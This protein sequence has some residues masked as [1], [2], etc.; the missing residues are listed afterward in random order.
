MEEHGFPIAPAI[1]GLVLGE[2]LEQSFMT[3]MIKADGNFI[4]FFERPIAAV[5]GVMTIL[6]WATMIWRG[7]RGQKA[8]IAPSE[9]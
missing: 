4:D 8:T 5:L 2:L 9:A 6:I 3:S 1:L 7:I